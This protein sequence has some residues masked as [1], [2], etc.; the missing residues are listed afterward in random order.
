MFDFVRKHTKIMMIVLFLL[1]IPS[2]VLFGLDGYS[3]M[4]E[5]GAA[6]A[7]VDGRD[8]SQ[9]E[10]DQAHKQE[11]DRLRSSMPSLDPKL[12]DSPEAALRHAGAP[13]ARPRAGAWPASGFQ[14][15]D[16][17]PAAGAG[18]AGQRNHCLFA[19]PDGKLDM[20]RYRQL[21][22]AQGMT[23]EMFEARARAICRAPGDGGVAG[24][25]S[26]RRRQADVALNAFSKSVKC[27]SRAFHGG[28]R[29]ACQPDRCRIEQ[30]Y[31]D[32]PRCSRRRAGQY[33]VPGAGPGGAAQGHHP[34]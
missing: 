22:G 21:V 30:F 4:Q 26:R 13:G 31:K 27:R 8:I 34:Q 24:P 23:P 14:P 1:I 5:K 33:R 15:G 19:P 20:E 9:T 2:F 11:V 6:V 7:K 18:P 12:L 17:R 28:V 29:D 10:W 32:N 25:A 16:Q 3:R